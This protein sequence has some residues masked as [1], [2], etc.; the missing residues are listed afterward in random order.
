MAVDNDTLVRE[1]RKTT[2]EPGSYPAEQAR[3]LREAKQL[4]ARSEIKP[5]KAN[6]QASTQKTSNEIHAD[7][8]GDG[9]SIKPGEFDIPLDLTVPYKAFE[10][11]DLI[12]EQKPEVPSQVTNIFAPDTVKKPSQIEIEG[13][14]LEVPLQEAE[15]IKSVDG[16]GIVIK[17]KR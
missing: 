4:K 11:P 14:I 16:A 10:N 12:M 7:I 2:L 5:D 6:P 17:L 1:N 13:D 8:A 9:K 3:Q 15:K